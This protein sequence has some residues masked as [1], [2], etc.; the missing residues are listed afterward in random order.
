LLRFDRARWGGKIASTAIFILWT[1]IA[2][3]AQISNPQSPGPGGPGSLNNLANLN[4][5]TTVL[6]DALMA[7]CS[8]KDAA[9]SST[10]TKRNAEA[11]ARMTPAARST[12]LKRFVL[13]DKPGE[14]NASGDVY[15]KIVV[16]CTTPQ[17]TTE[18]QIG[19]AEI[20][21]NL[22]YVPLTV[23]DTA[24]SGNIDAHNVTMG[25]VKES[26]EWKLLSLGLL[27]LDLPS[28]EAEWD[29]AEIKSNEAAALESLKK[30][31]AAIE[32]YRNTYTR[33]PDSLGVLGP[34]A[35]GSVASSKGSNDKVGLL[36]AALSEGR[37]EGYAFRYVVVGANNLGAPAKY[38][39]AAIP[40]EYGR[41]GTL[42]YFRDADGVLHAGD[43]KGTVGSA[44]DPAIK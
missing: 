1:G 40:A 5:P 44:S 17:L 20:R 25:M 34:V 18:M 36:D 12:L 7:A 21:E 3:A 13:L 41:G 19:K 6:R 15:T 16:H 11:F 28:L 38:E 4:S 39:L 14:P 9:F 42:S 31:V 32:S 43:H 10:L 30:L 37:K 23:K 29:R 27:L 2:G 33:L 35:A 8:Q 24:D 22:A 26:G